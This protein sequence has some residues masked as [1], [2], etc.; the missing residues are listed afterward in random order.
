MACL[1]SGNAQITAAVIDVHGSVSKSGDATFS[2]APVTKAATVSDPLAGLPVPS[3]TGLT[4]F[5]SY[6]LS[7]NST[8]T[9]NPGIYSQISLSGNAN[10]TMN[11]GT[12]IIEGGGFSVS[13][14]AAITGTGVTIYDAGSKFP[15]TGGTFG[16]ITL[17]GNGTYKLTPPTTGPYANV[18]FLQPLANTQVLTYSGNAMAGV[19]GTIY[20]PGAQLVESGNAQLN[21]ALVVD[22]LTLSGNAISNVASLAAPQGSTAYT[23]AQVRAAYGINTLS[24]DGSGETIAI[25]DAYDNPSIYPAVDAFDS[26]FG[27][28]A[29]GPSLLDQYG[30]ASS[31]LTI[32]NQDGQTTSLP[33]TD[34][35]GPGTDNWEVEESLDVEWAHAVAPG[36]RI[37]LVE[38]NS[39]SLSDL[40]SG[41]ATAA[42]QPGVSVVSMSWGFAEGQNISSSDEAAYDAVLQ[43]PGVTFVASTGDYGAA[44][45]EYPAYSP[46][47][48][49][50]GGTTL[51][52][53]ADNSYDSELGW[54]NVSSSNGTLTGSG[55]GI[56]LFEPEPAFQQ[57]VQ[58]TG[59]RTIPDVSLVADPATGGWIADPYNIPGAIPFEVVGGTS[60]SAPAWAGLLALADQ[61]RASSGVAALN[62]TQPTEAGQA[63]YSL[64]QSDFNVIAGGN[65]GYDAQS[66]YNLVTGLGTPVASLLIPDLVAY[67]GPGTT[68]AGARVAP[69]QNATLS[70]AGSDAGGST[71][72]VFNVFDSLTYQSAGDDQS[73]NAGI[74]TTSNSLQGQTTTSATTSDQWRPTFLPAMSILIFALSVTPSPTAGIVLPIVA[75]SPPATAPP[76]IAITP[77]SGGLATHSIS[78]QAGSTSLFET[79]AASWQD[80]SLPVPGSLRKGQVSDWVLNDLVTGLVTARQAPPS[81][82]SVFCLFLW[83]PRPP[84]VIRDD[85][86]SIG[87]SCASLPAGPL[88]RPEQVLPSRQ[89]ARS[90]AEPFLIAGFC[91]FGAGLLALRKPRSPL[92]Y[93]KPNR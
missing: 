7:G 79:G 59:S 22:T 90:Q 71:Q 35:N 69:L 48:V 30:P 41:V 45:P 78:A 39:Q 31:F 12:Y 37:I 62:S 72:D 34:P 80:E 50:V 15:S 4:N 18:L 27:V 77:T 46:N 51:T 26:Q 8:A 32:L 87:A 20:V 65:N 10:L 25:V 60:L 16:A 13:G 21:A 88:S 33:A 85:G 86:Q 82:P 92:S 24:L 43:A 23:P 64:P 83:S 2:P 52:L 49:A 3:T 40:M 66:G 5:G 57:G 6:S 68:Y 1:A 19:S 89:P 70:G 17:S 55:G 38:T 74:T 58:S 14:N 11:A 61:G 29:T 73:Q 44:D 93:Q 63:L 75:A 53:A 76:V 28:T 91:G 84:L 56:S 81:N 47:V 54:G 67:H 9:I 42:S 36:A